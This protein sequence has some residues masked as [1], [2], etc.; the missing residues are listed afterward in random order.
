MYLSEYSS[1]QLLIT[2]LYYIL[3]IFARN[4]VMIFEIECEET[5]E[6]LTVKLFHLF[7]WPTDDVPTSTSGLLVVEWTKG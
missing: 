3:F 7:D 1:F 5:E 6:C 4:Q 2:P